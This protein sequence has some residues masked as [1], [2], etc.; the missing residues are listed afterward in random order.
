MKQDYKAFIA[1][2]SNWYTGF[3]YTISFLFEM[4][5]NTSLQKYISEEA[6]LSQLL[7]ES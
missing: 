3:D 7:P 5:H 2:L 6:F 1:D 4:F